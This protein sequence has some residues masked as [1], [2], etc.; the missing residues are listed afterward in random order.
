MYNWDR[1]DFEVIRRIFI[2]LL[3]SIR[4]WLPSILMEIQGCWFFFQVYFW[5]LSVD[6]RNFV[7]SKHGN[8]NKHPVTGNDFDIPEFLYK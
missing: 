8:K 6:S 3:L 1:I 4:S 5:A 2:L 7:C